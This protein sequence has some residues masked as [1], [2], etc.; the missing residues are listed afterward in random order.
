MQKVF[1]GLAYNVTGWRSADNSVPSRQATEVDYLVNVQVIGFCR[2][3]SVSRN[4]S[5]N[6]EP[7]VD[8]H[9]SSARIFANL[10]VIRRD[11]SLAKKMAA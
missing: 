4:K 11:L 3:H 1:Q 2:L 10:H 9:D 5:Q 7:K 8:E 6:K